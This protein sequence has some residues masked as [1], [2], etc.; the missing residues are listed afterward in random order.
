MFRNRT[1]RFSFRLLPVALFALTTV[2]SAPAQSAASQ[3]AAPKD[4]SPTPSKSAPSA[5]P[6]TSTQ[7]AASA[8]KPTR[9]RATGLPRRARSFYQMRWGVDSFTVKSVESGEMIRFS[10]RI[11]DA[12]KAKALNDKHNEPALLDE[13]AQVKLAIPTL[14]KVG[15]LRQSTA[16]EA[17]KI[18]WMVFSNKERYVKPGHRVSVVIGDFRI[19]GLL[20]E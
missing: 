10:Y 1:F 8:G 19:D 15:Q 11:L 18:Y 16:P 2:V 13:Q 20:V 9:Y 17:G 5:K 7:A 14:E 12:D 4:Q 3:S 6:A